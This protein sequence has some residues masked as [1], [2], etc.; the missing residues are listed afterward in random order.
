MN[1]SGPSFPMYSMRNHY[2]LPNMNNNNGKKVQIK[3]FV[4][5]VIGRNENAPWRNI[6]SRQSFLFF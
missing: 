6:M 5:E 2:K 3:S 1:K 4:F